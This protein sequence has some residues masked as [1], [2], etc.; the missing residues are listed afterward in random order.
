MEWLLLSLL[1]AVVVLGIAYSR[2]A[3]VRA[4]HQ[5]SISLV[6]LTNLDRNLQHQDEY[7]KS[8]L[9][10]VAG[11]YVQDVRTERL[12]GISLDE[13]KKYASGARL[14][15]LKDF[16][17]RNLA[18]MQGWSASRLT[19][20]RGVGPKSASL[21]AYA[22][23]LL[24][25]QSNSLPVPHPVLASERKRDRQ[26][27]G[28]A[29]LLRWNQAS[30][31]AKK[32]E[33]QPFIGQ[34]RA[35]RERVYARANFLHWLIGFDG[36]DDVRDGIKEANT[37]ANRL[38]GSDPVA[39]LR[40]GVVKLLGQADAFRVN[41]VE[42]EL[43]VKDYTADTVGYTRLL[44]AYL[45]AFGTPTIAQ[46][47]A[48]VREP[49]TVQVAAPPP[50]HVNIPPPPPSFS[51]TRSQAS[52]EFW[53]PPG[54]EVTMKGYSIKD[55]MVYAG[56]DLATACGWGTEPSLINPE[57]FVAQ[58]GVDCHV[59]NTS[60]WPSYD[61]ISPEARASYLQWLSQG[62]SDPQADIGYVF[63]YFYGL[64]R[65]VLVDVEHD[66][67]AKAELPVMEKE[68]RRLLGIYRN[69]GS[70]RSYA[71]SLLDYLDARECTVS[72]LESLL[73]LSLASGGGLDT[74]L[75]VGLGLHAQ[76]GKPLSAD[77]A[78][79]WYL[80]D[81]NTPRFQTMARCPDLFASLFKVEYAK[82]FGEGLT[83][84]VNKTRIKVTHRPASQSLS[85]KEFHANLDLPE[86]SV[87]SGPIGR[88]QEIGEACHAGLAP[89]G[90]YLAAHAGDGKC[91]EALLLLPICLWP[92]D[93]SRSF[94]DVQQAIE[95]AG[96][97]KVLLLRELL[98]L[99]PQGE[100][101]NRRRFKE[102]SKALAGFGF[103]IEPDVRF[104]GDLPEPEEAIA[105]FAAVGLDQ[106]SPVTERYVSASVML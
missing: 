104:G 99:L 105:L 67:S 37:T 57:L 60:Y 25:K 76:E 12:R 92:E 2:S 1:V 35:S 33:L 17:I 30:I 58:A 80:R 61:S 49:V 91:L 78:F 5:A 90:R 19:Q 6:A 85:G 98:S 29:Y 50:V 69:N 81:P 48:A 87:L 47:V 34:F 73:Q 56:S 94:R 53:I 96:F 36:N 95:A 93:I 7:A 106:D 72:S 59:R 31:P 74:H 42:R 22:A 65:R 20:I 97:P 103:G 8:N 68:I 23:D 89:Y 52:S 41:G 44:T 3:A 83:L 88:L 18:D 38:L 13:L 14:Q 82:R 46:P 16:G 9:A 51:R 70:F 102:L 11:S 4:R 39:Q 79:A 63:L 15:A 77:W 64:E 101:L 84:P 45:A 43:I 66:A 21:M 40:R 86:V 28:A 27:L 24:T 26:L 55:G 10:R 71:S 75:R 100:P 54:H 32:R 62:K